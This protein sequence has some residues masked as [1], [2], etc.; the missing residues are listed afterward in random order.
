MSDSYLQPYRDAQDEHGSA[1]D[2]TMWA[3]P[4]TQTRRFAVFAEMLELNHKR[5]LDAGCSRG[6][7]AEWL[8]DKGHP[9]THYHGVDGLPDVIA[10]A[11]TRGL[12]R[13]SFAAGDFVN[14]PELLAETKP[15]ITLI[16]GTLN[17]MDDA[18]ALQV[19]DAAWTGCTEALAFNF[20]SDTSGPN[21]V[22]QQYP[23]RR[24]PTRKLLDWALN[25]TPY[26]KMRQDYFPE[27]HDAT[28]VMRRAMGLVA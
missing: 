21:A 1:F 19:L 11:R 9:Y 25:Q 12:E 22:P 28:I 6:D 26:V 2:V 7:L 4:E 3:R 27:G 18:T 13:A 5:V 24:L 23:A 14:Q 15:D 20:L 8:L 16:S 17:T 10:F